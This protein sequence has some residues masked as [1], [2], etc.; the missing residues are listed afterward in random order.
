M[1][2]FD[3]LGMTLDEIREADKH[4]YSG[5]IA[6]ETYESHLSGGKVLSLDYYRHFGRPFDADEWLAKGAAGV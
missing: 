6:G 2:V 4:I 3:V 1:N 5:I